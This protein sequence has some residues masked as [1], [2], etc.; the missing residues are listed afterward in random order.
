MAKSLSG[1]LPMNVFT[2]IFFSMRAGL[3]LCGAIAALSAVIT[4]IDP[5]G[6]LFRSAAFQAL[7]IIFFLQLTACTLAQIRR[8]GKMLSGSGSSPP[9]LTGPE[10]C[11]AR[12]NP[13]AVLGRVTDYLRQ[14]NYCTRVDKNEQYLLR[15]EKG[16]LGKAAAIVLHL[17]ILIILVAGFCGSYFGFQ[18]IVDAPVGE[19]VAVRTDARSGQTVRGHI[20]LRDFRID[21]YP[22]GGVSEFTSDVSFWAG[23]GEVRGS[24]TVNHPL[25]VFGLSIQQFGYGY[26]VRLQAIGE[27]QPAAWFSEYSVI[28]LNADNSELLQILGYRPQFDD[29][30]YAV[31]AGNRLLYKA[32]QPL[33]R[34][35]VLPGA[36]QQWVFGGVKKYSRLQIKR[37]PGIPFVFGGFLLLVIAFF[38]TVLSPHH[39][40]YLSLR[41]E[42]QSV[43]V[44][45]LLIG[46]NPYRRQLSAKIEQL[47][48]VLDASHG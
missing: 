43:Y 41:E 3:L 15:A 6:E 23:A 26:R 5:A 30:L 45:T 35:F 12:E 39:I 10:F 32:S 29:V 22:D 28:P 34:P 31:Y 46:G 25:D 24:V 20:L 36:G 11:V 44:K 40:I 17:A 1:S 8:F 38:A 14:Q 18:A 9:R 19:K 27:R 37:D 47:A 42:G 33:D 2:R 13:E 21:Y 7:L 16:V 48:K 4:V